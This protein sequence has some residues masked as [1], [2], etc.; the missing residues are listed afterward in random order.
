MSFAQWEVEQGGGAFVETA[1]NPGSGQASFVQPA[2]FP[3]MYLCEIAEARIS[4]RG[5]QAMF[6]IQLSKE[7]KVLRFFFR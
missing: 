7:G 1:Q 4:E 5:E 3:E 2:V 6:E